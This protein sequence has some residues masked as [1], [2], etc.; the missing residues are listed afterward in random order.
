MAVTG[1]RIEHSLDDKDR[2][3]K[4]IEQA[5]AGEVSDIHLANG[6]P[7]YWRSLGKLSP[8]ADFIPRQDWLDKVV[9]DYLGLT[10]EQLTRLHGERDL[11][12]AYSYN[13]RRFRGNVYYQQGGLALALR[14][15][16]ANI[17]TLADINAPKALRD[18]A[19]TLP[20][21]LI[22]VCGATG[23]GKTTTLAAFLN[24]I[25]QRE[26]RHIITLEDPIEYILPPAKSFISQREFSNDFS[27]FDKALR[28]ALREDPDIIMV[29][30]IRDEGTLRTALMAAMTGVLVLGSLH[31]G[32]AVDTARRVENMVA[33][34]EQE[35]IRGQL[36]EVLVGIFSQELVLRA[37]GTRTALTEVLLGT[38]AVK[39]LIRQGKL[40]Q[41]EAGMMSG[42]AMGMQTREMAERE[43]RRQGMI[44]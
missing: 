29:G 16:P 19:V 26:A 43:L 14:L 15:L 24:E 9:F 41:L 25:N 12:L 21:G 39:N 36:A 28:S 27:R 20:K 8:Q 3:I 2:W 23:A 31:T 30:E 34:N 13:G 11:D 32:G 10:A 44:D 35:I 33:L 1:F 22:L 18:M 42:Q 38:T 7:V 5:I 37:D 6:Q 4:L 17:P 40:S